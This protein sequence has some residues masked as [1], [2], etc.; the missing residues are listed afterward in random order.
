MVGRERFAV[1]MGGEEHI[2]AIE[3]GERHVRGVALLGVHEHVIG[4]RPELHQLQNVTE[5]NARPRVVKAAPARDAVEVAADLRFRQAVEFLPAQPQRFLDQPAQVEIPLRGIEA[6][7]RSV[8][9]HGP[10]QG[11]RLPRRQASRLPHFA[12]AL[13]AL[14]AF[15]K[16]SCEL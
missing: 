2:V 7:H 5:E 13:L 10:F 3:V 14:V 9:Q 15:E 16:H 4:F 6:R 8:M 1:V 12:F 11:E